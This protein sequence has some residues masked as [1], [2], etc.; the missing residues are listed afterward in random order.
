MAMYV[1]I[2]LNDIHLN[3]PSDG[4]KVIHVNGL[5]SACFSVMSRDLNLIV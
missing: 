4:K 3:E 5:I 1:P 2:S